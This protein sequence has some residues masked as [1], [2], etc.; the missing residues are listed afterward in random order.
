MNEEFISAL[1]QVAEE[2]K[3]S[4]ESILEATEA[5]LAA[6]YR[7]DY[8]KPSQIIRCKIDPAK[9][10]ME[11]WMEKK[12]VEEVADENSEILLKDA[13]KEDKNAE[14]EGVIKYPLPTHEDFGRIAAQTAKQVIIQRL[15]E[16]EREVVF[17][18]FKN[19]EGQM[20]NGVVQQMEGGNVVIDLGRTNGIMFP[21]DQIMGEHYRV[22]QRIKVVVSLV[23]KTNRGSQILVSRTHDDLVRYLFM[24]EVPEIESGAVAIMGIAREAGVRTKMS[25]R[26]LQ[27]GVDPVGSCVGQRGTRVQ[28]VLSE[29]GN[30]KIDIVLWNE[31]P[32]TYITNA[33][34]PAKVE[35][36][37]L[38][39]KLQEA[40]VYVANEQLSLAIG[41]NGQNVRLA[42]K[43]TGWK[44]DVVEAG[45][46]P[47][48]EFVEEKEETVETNGSSSEKKKKE[49]KEKKTKKTTVKKEKK[50]KEETVEANGSSSEHAERDGSPEKKENPPKADKKKKSKKKV[51]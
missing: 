45:T 46:K 33:L 24:M 49:V 30:E 19:M 40:L 2:K 48:K 51:K 7:K 9:G 50:V 41:K 36:V 39:K 10:S 15:K 11:F 47:A 16:V 5:A 35:D 12:I 44:I 3:I 32:A 13:K 29:I 22:G 6:A 25:V 17:N 27:E 31:D 28:A 37:K 26:A 18:E 38:S 20:V 21:S 23:E 42:A 14:L 8:G 4:K 43:L 34:S 1:E